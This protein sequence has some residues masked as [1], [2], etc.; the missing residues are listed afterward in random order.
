MAI[1]KE[2][3]PFQGEGKFR[4]AG[5]RAE[6]QMAFYLRRFFA[7]SPDVD[8]LNHLRIELGGEVAQMDHLVI[9]PYGFIIVESKSVTGSVQIKDDGQ[10]IRWYEKKPSGMQSPLTQARMQGM[11]LKELLSSKVQQKGFFDQVPVDVLV[12]ISDQGT[13]QWPQTGALAEVCK[14]DQV[15]ERIAQWLTRFDL[16]A[17]SGSATGVLPAGHRQR[18]AQFLLAV[19]QPFAAGSAERIEKTNPVATQA[20]QMPVKGELP[21]VACGKCGK[22]DGLEIRYGKGSYYFHCAA[23]EGN[24]RLSF[25]CPKC[26]QDGRLSKRGLQFFAE[27]HACDASV[28]Y[29]RNPV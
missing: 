12:A 19:H 26:G 16:K 11:L 28:S 18:I 5:H 7:N 1:L 25:S 21:K 10:W 8:V 27:C 22:S 23:C 2:L 20:P 14:A 4:V 29:F 6:E 3:D 24:T 9:H 17:K 13:I 15:P